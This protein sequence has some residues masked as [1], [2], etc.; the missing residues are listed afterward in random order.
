MPQ[1][2]ISPKTISIA[3]SILVL[4]FLLGFYIFAWQEPTVSP[5]GGNV[6]AP[7]NVGPLPQAKTGRLS[8][9]ELYLNAT[10]PEGNI[11]YIDTIIGYN[12]VRIWGKGNKK[13]PIYLEGSKVIINN[14]PETGN[15]GIGLI[16]PLFKLDVEGD[17]G[18]RAFCLK[19]KECLTDWETLKP[20]N[21]S[22]YPAVSDVNV[23]QHGLLNVKFI[24][25]VEEAP[26]IGAWN[27]DTQ[28]QWHSGTFE[29]TEAEAG[30][31]R[32]ATVSGASFTTTWQRHYD[33]GH[34]DRFSDVACDKDENTI[35]VGERRG[36][37]GYW[38]PVILKYDNGGNLVFNYLA[39]SEDKKDSAIALTTDS[40]NNFIVLHRYTIRK[41]SSTG[42]LIWK[43]ELS[44]IIPE[45]DW[46]LAIKTDSQDNIIFT[47]GYHLVKLDP[48]GNLLWQ[49]G[50]DIFWSDRL[51]VLA[52]DQE[53]NILVGRTIYP[54]A[55]LY[56]FNSAGTFLWY[57]KTTFDSLT[58]IGTD[59]QNNIYG[60]EM[61]RELGKYDS[62]GNF[63]KKEFSYLYN[64]RNQ[65][66]GAENLDNLAVD[67]AD[68]II[69]TSGAQTKKYNSDL[70]LLEETTY[71]FSQ[72]PGSVCISPSGAYSVGTRTTNFNEDI[73]L[74]RYG[75]IV[76]KYYSKGKYY[77]APH[78]FGTAV[79][80]QKF[81]ARAKLNGGTVKV[82]IEVSDD[83]F[84]TIKGSKTIYLSDGNTNV[85]LANLP[86]SR[87]IRA[88]LELK[89]P[90]ELKT[91]K[92]DY[93]QVNTDAQ[94]FK[95]VDFQGSSIKGV[96]K[97][98]VGTVD[99]IFKIGGKFYASYM[100]ES[101]GA[102]V[103]ITGKGKLENGKWEIDL[104][105][106]PEGSD[107]WLFWQIV[108]PESITIQITPE[109]PLQLG[110]KIV[111]GKFI[112]EALEPLNISFSYMLLGTRLDFA[113]KS[114]E[115]INRV[116]D[117]S[118]KGYID[119]DSLKK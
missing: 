4:L 65:I 5:P 47:K 22:L 107:L 85:S 77:S 110:G 87:Y 49:K 68:N 99:P 62:E 10:A 51:Q 81:L 6:P 54:G 19:G 72:K 66:T 37:D 14:D 96:S 34:Q 95:V 24:Q 119:I 90:D 30:W 44:D 12:D 82:K 50:Y 56:K 67:Q 57:E 79:S 52:I 74:I 48:N 64:P 55:R 83:G 58:G 108:D 70:K 46:S 80:F 106:Q 113:S 86:A 17:I 39:K 20:L 114:P 97:L 18:A 23:N 32:L 8:L 109:E 76:E 63:L 42:N 117:Q 11:K 116:F 35:I 98:T 27:I 75:G 112:V 103:Q 33:S 69:V 2:K 115:E 15:V 88:T 3:F 118:L 16:N 105:Q 7:L 91:P 111:K 60:V 31:L 104:T 21:W 41:F 28:A 53:D 43:K 26:I 84:V 36:V 13:A 45:T 78:D 25:G 89:T 102:K 9:P 101:I 73:T 100:L 1:S 94:S 59:S 38:Y 71:A 92:V 29:K 40:E 93:I 61:G